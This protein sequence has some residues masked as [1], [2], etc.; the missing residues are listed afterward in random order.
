MLISQL[1]TGSSC[2]VTETTHCGEFARCNC[3]NSSRGVRAIHLYRVLILVNITTHCGEFVRYICNN[4]LRG[5][6]AIYYTLNRVNWLLP[7]LSQLITGSFVQFMIH[8]SSVN[9]VYIFTHLPSCTPTVAL[10][11]TALHTPVLF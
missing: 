3:H 6:R 11:G 1:I 4:S 9:V 2:D 7:N 10:R 5:V 8:Y